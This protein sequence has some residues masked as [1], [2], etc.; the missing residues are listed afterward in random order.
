MED[1]TMKPPSDPGFVH[2]FVPAEKPSL[3]TLLLLHGTGGDERPVR[4]RKG[5]VARRSA[6]GG[7]WQGAGERK[8]TLFPEICGGRVL[9]I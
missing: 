2:I 7:A 3:P 4:A 1:K 8:A 5:L 6:F 9:M